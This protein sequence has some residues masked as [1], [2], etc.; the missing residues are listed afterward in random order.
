M[1]TCP[2]FLWSYNTFQLH[3]YPGVTLSVLFAALNMECGDSNRRNLPW[4]ESKHGKAIMSS[5]CR[6][7]RRE[8]LRG[9]R[10]R[11]G[12]QRGKRYEN[13][14]CL[15][16]G[17]AKT[18]HSSGFPSLPRSLLHLLLSRLHRLFRSCWRLPV[19]PT[20]QCMFDLEGT[21]HL[22]STETMVCMPPPLSIPLLDPVRHGNAPS[23][24]HSLLWSVTGCSGSYW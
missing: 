10:K 1:A 14:T 15:R 23:T 7:G 13:M 3:K 16:I 19:P 22:K 5:S 4:R 18:I 12:R 17:S 9:E 24:R 2:F 8:K 11:E 6:A 20:T 21:I